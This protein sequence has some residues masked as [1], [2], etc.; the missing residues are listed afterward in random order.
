MYTALW[1][2][3]HEGEEDILRTRTG[4]ISL[5]PFSERVSEALECMALHALF[6]ISKSS[7]GL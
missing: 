3:M 7:V 4:S 6:S 2:I 5:F 1:V